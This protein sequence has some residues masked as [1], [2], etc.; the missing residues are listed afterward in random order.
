M[1]L[2]GC[3]WVWS[4]IITKQLENSGRTYDWSDKG[5]GKAFALYL[6]LVTGF[7][8]NYLYLYFVCGTLVEEPADIIRIG[9]LLRATESAAQAVSYGL[10]AIESFGLVGASALNFGLWAVA[11]IPAWFTIREIGVTYWGRGEKE[12][13]EAEALV[14]GTHAVGKG[15]EGTLPGSPHSEKA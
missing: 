4:T 13:K 9:G 5:F 15:S 6:F 10:N 8:L 14:Y 3:W 12:T 7:Q 11:V 1:G 2:Q